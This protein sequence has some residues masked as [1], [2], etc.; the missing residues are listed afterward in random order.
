MKNISKTDLVACM[1]KGMNQK[2]M[3]E[4][5]NCSIPTLHKYLDKHELR[6]GLPKEL[7]TNAWTLNES[8]YAFCVKLRADY[9]VQNITLKELLEL[10]QEDLVGIYE[11]YQKKQSMP[12]PPT[13]P[14]PLAQTVQQT[15]PPPT[16]SVSDIPREIFYPDPEKEKQRGI[17]EARQQEIWRKE[18]AEY[19]DKKSIRVAKNR[20]NQKLFYVKPVNPYTMRNHDIEKIRKH[21]DGSITIKALCGPKWHWTKQ[22]LNGKGKKVKELNV[23]YGNANKEKEFDEG[24]LGYKEMVI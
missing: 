2:E 7:K 23:A 5:L 12:Q 3:A 18:W 13:Q 1:Q 20:A 21:S 6:D 10:S 24:F 16:K 4:T 14:V 22:E 19:K 17:E 11:E 9:N 15:T 8:K